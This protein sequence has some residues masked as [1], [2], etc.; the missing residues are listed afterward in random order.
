MNQYEKLAILIPALADAAPLAYQ[1]VMEAGWWRT[2]PLTVVQALS[3]APPIVGVIV[4][5]TLPILRHQNLIPKGSD[6]FLVGITFAI[7]GIFEP[8][9]YWP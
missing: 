5:I 2:A 6:C 7:L 4:L 9:L 8:I 1:F 3:L